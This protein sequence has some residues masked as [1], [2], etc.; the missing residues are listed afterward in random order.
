MEPKDRLQLTIARYE[1]EHAR[2][3]GLDASL[4]AP[5]AAFSALFA[6]N[7][8]LVSRLNA[9]SSPW[10]WGVAIHSL[11][12]MTVAAIWFLRSFWLNQYHYVALPLKQE[13]WLEDCAARLAARTAYREKYPDAAR[14]MPPDRSA[15]ESYT[16]HLIQQYGEYAAMCFITNNRRAWCRKWGIGFVVLGFCILA[17]AL[18]LQRVLDF[19]ASV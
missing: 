17:V 19:R 9:E 11:A 3:E 6:G 7:I 2:K 5:F 12:V 1:S 15:E 10:T 14:S 16:L 4:T 13:A 18:V 8:F